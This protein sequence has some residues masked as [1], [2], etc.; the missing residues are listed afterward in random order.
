MDRV[1]LACVIHATNKLV[2]EQ[3]SPSTMVN[4]R[5]RARQPPKRTAQVVSIPTEEPPVM[6][7][8][9]KLR[10]K[11]KPTYKAAQAL[12]S[13]STQSDEPIDL[14]DN[15]RDLLAPETAPAERDTFLEKAA[16]LEKGLGIE[17]V[18]MRKTAGVDNDFV[19]SDTGSEGGDESSSGNDEDIEAEDGQSI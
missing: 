8:A 13:P 14:E 16:A 2:I 17:E 12:S 6:P 11:P 19:Q 10:P 4:Q 1:W 9:P 3:T 7:N 15:A 5:K 18:V